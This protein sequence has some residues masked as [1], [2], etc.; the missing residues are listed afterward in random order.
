MAESTIITGQF[1]RISQVCLKTNRM[2]IITDG[3][4]YI[5]IVVTHND[6]LYF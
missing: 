6:I 4:S 3:E 2:T 1:V 5:L